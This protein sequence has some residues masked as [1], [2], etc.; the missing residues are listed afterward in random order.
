MGYRHEVK[1]M[2]D[3]ENTV[4]ADIFLDGCIHQCGICRNG[5]AKERNSILMNLGH[6]HHCMN[7]VEKEICSGL[8]FSGGEPLSTENLDCVK[9]IVSEMRFN[10]IEKPIRLRTCYSA[11]DLSKE[12]LQF[13]M[14]NRVS[15]TF[16]DI[17]CMQKLTMASSEVILVSN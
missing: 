9:F 4:W 10:R 1:C 2:L 8:Q 16:H 12:T 7:V 14:D 17:S 6:V 3:D 13:L 5:A 15:V 11:D